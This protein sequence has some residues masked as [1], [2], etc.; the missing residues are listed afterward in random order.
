MRKA[1]IAFGID[2]TVQRHASQL[3]EIHF[4]TIHSRYG[5]ARV[6]QTNKGDLLIGP[7]LPKDVQRIRS[8]SQNFHA[9]ALEFFIFIPKTRQ[10][11]A[12]VGS[13]KAAQERQQDRLATEAG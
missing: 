12:A 8:D 5:M 11:R 3:E 7:I 13:G 4:L 2:D 10:L 1:D 9:A 6:R